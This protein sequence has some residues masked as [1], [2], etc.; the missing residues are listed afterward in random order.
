MLSARM[1]SSWRLPELRS[2]RQ[3]MLGTC[4]GRTNLR[5]LSVLSEHQVCRVIRSTLLRSH[6]LGAVRASELYRILQE[7]L[8]ERDLEF[9]IAPYSAGPQVN[10]QPRIMIEAD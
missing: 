5:R 2:R 6:Q 7:V 8:I 1:R 9:L 10:L 4:M 3:T